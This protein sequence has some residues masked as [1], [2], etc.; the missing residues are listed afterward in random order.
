MTSLG[1]ARHSVRAIGALGRRA[2]RALRWPRRPAQGLLRPRP[3]PNQDLRQR[4]PRR[5][6]AARQLHA[7][8]ADAARRATA[9]TTS[10]NGWLLAGHAPPLRQVVEHAPAARSSGFISGNQQDPDMICEVFVPPLYSLQPLVSHA[11][12]SR[13]RFTTDGAGAGSPRGRR[14]PA[15]AVSLMKRIGLAIPA[16]PHRSA[17]DGAGSTTSCRSSHAR[18][19]RSAPNL[20]QR[21]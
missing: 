1:R 12:V 3:R 15:A 8:R 21:V 18:T 17:R 10:V 19:T 14:A 11:R 13:A 5:L 2:H 6:P 9:T 20:R 7:R 16:P 4:R